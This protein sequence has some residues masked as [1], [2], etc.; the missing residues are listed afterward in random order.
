MS[1]CPFPTTVTITPRIHLSVY[2]G[3]K[4]GSPGRSTG[5]V[6]TFPIEIF[7]D[8]STRLGL[9]YALRLGNQVHGICNYFCV[10][11]KEFFYTPFILLISCIPD[12]NNLN[13]T[14]WF[15]TFP[16]YDYNYMGDL[17]AH[18]YMVSSYY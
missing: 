2:I 16:F 7:Y 14:E 12:I 18:T 17:F 10:F 3:R 8:I 13:I 11:F 1:L 4:Q 5:T 6:K 15:Q 9:F